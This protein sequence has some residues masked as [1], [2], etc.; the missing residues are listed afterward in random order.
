MQSQ[1]TIHS[2]SF[3]HSLINNLLDKYRNINELKDEAALDYLYT[4]YYQ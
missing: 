4:F 2:A 3:C 1:F